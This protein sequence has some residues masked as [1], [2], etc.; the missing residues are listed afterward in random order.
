MQISSLCYFLQ[1]LWTCFVLLCSG[2]PL[3]P[4]PTHTHD[5][6][7]AVEMI[8]SQRWCLLFPVRSPCGN[9]SA[10][11]WWTQL[12]LL[13]LVDVGAEGNVKAP[14]PSPRLSLPLPFFLPLSK[15][16]QQGRKS[17]FTK[18]NALIKRS[19]HLGRDRAI[20]P[21]ASLKLSAYALCSA[22]SCHGN[23]AT[24]HLTHLLLS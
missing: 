18:L 12:K 1:T 4:P 13:S 24:G 7:P 5:R 22:I 2:T 19:D 9:Y 14:S 20:M 16:Q 23:T 6:T 8:A 21:T 10:G 17:F 11:L 3:T 15:D